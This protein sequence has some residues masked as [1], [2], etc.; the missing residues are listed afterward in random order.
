MIVARTNLFAAIG[1]ALLLLVIVELIRKKHLRE[2][3][4]LIWVVT[5]ALFLFISLR[6]DLLYKISSAFGFAV[7]S[8]ALFFFLIL[9]LILIS[10]GL[11]VI[12]SKLAERNK[13]LTQQLVLLKKRVE[14]LEK[15]K[16]S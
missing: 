12:T 9:F 11:S 2:R 4:S 15:S 10:L 3:Y 1:S 7:P 13:V 5:G 8:N 14:D 6:T 16:D